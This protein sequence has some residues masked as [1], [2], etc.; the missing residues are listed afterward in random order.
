MT[1]IQGDINT[2]NASFFGPPSTSTIETLR[3]RHD[4][5]SSEA[6][7]GAKSRFALEGRAIAELMLGDQALAMINIAI[8]KASAISRPDVISRLMSLEDLQGARPMM[9]AF[10]MANPVVRRM[11]HKGFCNGFEGSYEDEQPGVIGAGHK[12]YDIVMQGTFEP[13]QDG[14]TFTNSSNG[15]EGERATIDRRQWSDVRATWRVAEK[16]MRL[17]E[18]D[19]SNPL[20]GS[21]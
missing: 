20:G 17:G 6:F 9:Q 2:M 1:I 18:D 5:E 13:T 15:F 12:H 4:F 21:L 19:P 7:V 3:E 8:N 16:L 11:Y 10:I 14:Y